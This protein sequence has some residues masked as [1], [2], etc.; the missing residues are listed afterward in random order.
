MVGALMERQRPG[1]SSPRQQRLGE[2]IAPLAHASICQ[3]Q[4]DVVLCFE[5]LLRRV[6]GDGMMRLPKP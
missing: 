1:S 6:A 5:A 2:L 3:M 4:R